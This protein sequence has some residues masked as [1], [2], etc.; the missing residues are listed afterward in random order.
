MTNNQCKRGSSAGVCVQNA[1]AFEDTTCASG[2]KYEPDAPGGLGGM[3]AMTTDGGTMGTCGSIGQTCCA[4]APACSDSTCTDGTC[5]ACEA[6]VAPGRRFTCVLRSN[7]TIWCAGDNTFG[8]LGLGIAGVPSATRIQVRAIDT[9]LITDATAIT[10]GRDHACA[11]RAGG[12]VWCWGANYSG[13]LGNGAPFPMT[14][15]PPPQAAAVQVVQTG[16]A[17][18]TGIV[19]IDAGY[20]D[21]CA[22]DGNGEMWCWGSN[23]HGQLGDNTNTYRS[24]AARV[25]AVGGVG[26]LSGVTALHVGE[27]TTC[28]STGPSVLCWGNNTRGQIGD[29]TLNDHLRPV[30]YGTSSS[31]G[32][33]Q[34]VVCRVE[35]DTSVKCS[36][37]A[38]HGRLGN[39]TYG[40]WD[41]SKVST[42]T[43][44]T[45]A[46][47]S[48][49]KGALQV[50]VS[51]VGCALMT[52]G[53]VMCWG[54]NT[55]GQTGNGD[56]STAPAKVQFLDRTPLTKVDRI[57]SKFTH[58]CAHRT[59]GEWMCWGRN[60]Q[61]ELA[62]GT[63]VNRG[64][65]IP[66]KGACP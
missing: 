39:G 65:P 2:Y 12:T 9:S 4:S 24:T 13:Q 6:E 35:A 57:V 41:K 1:C 50:V 10:A 23:N 18:L 47:G 48:V 55:H 37:Y 5:T 28:A 26:F 7:A 29:G 54:D 58:T 20:D 8:Q 15:G 66:L 59:T 52:D 51:G 44:V 45:A 21:T 19:E 63:F 42:P 49:F 31:V 33:G 53:T 16:G 27:E 32:A 34:D 11:I 14:G 30:A 62:D 64:Y 25:L 38:Q 36:G 22:R 60:G 40:F 61:G 43:A 3:C 46:D 56:G 17:P